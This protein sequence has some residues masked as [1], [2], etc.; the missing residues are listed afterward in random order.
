MKIFLIRHGRTDWNDLNLWQGNCDEPLNQAG[1][2]QARRLA[3]RLSKQSVQIVFSS[4]LSRAYQTAK[5]ISE[6][7]QVPIIVDERLKECEIS[8][9][10]GLTMQETLQRFGKEYQLW[11][12]H[13]DAQIDGV[14][15]LQ[16]VQD[17]LVQFIEDVLRKSFESIAVVSHAISLR[18]LICWVLNLPLNEHKNFSLDNASVTLIEYKSKFRLIYLND[19]CHLE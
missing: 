8:L 19:T 9:W 3:E 7:L 14:E 17:R 16:N 10:N 1:F 4:P 2:E 5:V 18:T 15:S 11:S 13:P 6:E 12:N